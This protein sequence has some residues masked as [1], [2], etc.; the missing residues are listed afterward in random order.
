MDKGIKNEKAGAS[1]PAIPSKVEGTQSS[2]QSK[3]DLNTNTSSEEVKKL[4][5][6][7]DAKESEII[8]LKEDLKAKTEQI[9]ALETE[10]REFKD[11]L[12]PEIEKIQ[13]ENK[14]L[15]AQVEKLQSGSGKNEPV[16]TEGKFT[17]IASFRGNQDG[18]GIFNIGDDVSHLSAERLKSL[19]DRELVK[20]G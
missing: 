10:H 19:V 3:L 5:G 1:T 8:S 2:D 12:K 15:K 20:E 4:Q 13:T 9:V 18:E 14:D 7:L 6:E 16:K 11:K 17:V